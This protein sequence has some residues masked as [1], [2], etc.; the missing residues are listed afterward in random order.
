[1]DARSLIN[2]LADQEKALLK[3]QFL[4]PCLQGGRVRVC[5]DGLIYE[6]TP[7]QA[8]FEGWG[9]FQA[10]DAKQ[11]GLIGPASLGKV[12]EYLAHLQPLRM[13]LAWPVTGRTWMAYPA[14]EGDAVQRFGLARPVL[15]HLAEDVQAFTQVQAR[16]DGASFWFEAV[17]RAADPRVGERLRGALREVEV[18]EDLNWK[19]LTPEARTVYGLA[20]DREMALAARENARNARRNAHARRHAQQAWIRDLPPVRHDEARL[21]R[22]LRFAGAD[23]RD[24]HDHGV[25]WTVEWTTQDGQNHTSAISKDDLTVMS[26]GLCLDGHDRDFDLQSL[27]GV[28]EQAEPW[29]F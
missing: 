29:A 1:M 5:L 27:V 2:H 13:L 8:D 10:V 24:V 21:H 20:L 23:L 14:H 12:D 3:S 7:Q 11:A 6:L 19:G 9:L 16:F 4:A 15:L 17:D 18:P 28:V 25:Y 26:A 22:A